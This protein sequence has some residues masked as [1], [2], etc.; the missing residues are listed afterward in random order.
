VNVTFIRGGNPDLR[1]EIADT[2]VIGLVY[3]PSFIE[4]Y[5]MS[6][7]WY[8]VDI[9]DSIASISEQNIVDQCFSNGVYCANLIRDVNGV[10]AKV[11]A[12]FLNLDLSRVEGWDLEMSYRME[13]NFFDNEIES[14]SVRVLAG[15]LGERTNT[16]FNG[17]P[18]DLVGSSTRPEITGNLTLAYSLGPWSATWQ[19]RYISD[20]LLNTNWVE[21]VDV[22][23]NTVPTYSFTNLRF[24]YQSEMSSGG[25]WTVSLA[26]NNAFDKNPPIIPGAFGR[27]GSQTGSG[28]G[29]DEFGRRYQLGL[30]MNF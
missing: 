2:N 24:A 6:L 29:Y 15:Y 12:P 27:I 8:E 18:I 10:L 5:R 11:A 21:G 17:A 3:E 25:D 19:Q 23:L 14:L 26:V 16:P 28:L 13:P 4:G 7:D 1:P 20:T 30:N 9:A 22:D